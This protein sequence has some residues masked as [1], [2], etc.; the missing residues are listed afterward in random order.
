M[1]VMTA[2]L[3]KKRVGI[4]AGVVL[5]LAVIILLLVRSPGGKTGTEQPVSLRTNDQRVSYLT[6]QGWDVVV[7]PVQTRQVLIPTELS[8]VFE[9][10]NTL[11]VSQGFDLTQYGG[12]TVT[13]YVYQ[14]ENFPNATDP[15]YATLL[16]YDDKIIGGDVTD[17]SAGGVMQGLQAGAAL[18]EQNSGG[19]I[20]S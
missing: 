2:K 8:E 15:V 4:I 10:Y 3:D 5:A 14:V 16:I 6:Q 13:Q 19:G 11:Q 18:P 20:I 12:K 17:T 1:F 7:S 9:R